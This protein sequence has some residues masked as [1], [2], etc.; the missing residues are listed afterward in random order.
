MYY[1]KDDSSVQDKDLRMQ[2]SSPY[3]YID[4]VVVVELVVR[5]A[6]RSEHHAAT[7][8]TLIPLRTSA[9]FSTKGID[10]LDRFLNKR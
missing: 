4:I 8:T 1:Y 6:E 5:P 3:M 10:H 2:H 7:E 9:I